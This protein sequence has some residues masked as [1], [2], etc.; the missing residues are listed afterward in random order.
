MGSFT[1]SDGILITDLSPDPV[2]SLDHLSTAFKGDT[3]SGIV[4]IVDPAPA[5]ALRDLLLRAASI[6]LLDVIVKGQADTQDIETTVNALMDRVTLSRLGD[7]VLFLLGLP[8]AARILVE[9][10]CGVQPPTTV[11]G[12]LGRLGWGRRR[13]ESAVRAY[14]YVWPLDFVRAVRVAAACVLLRRGHTVKDVAGRLAYGSTDTLAEHSRT[15][16]GIPPS[17]VRDLDE[18][19]LRRSL[20]VR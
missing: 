8:D 13:L 16:L 6:P 20:A 1:P 11:R 10:F 19:R 5:A 18:G 4:L 9:P 14:G 2:T 15:I 3:D 7:E 12:L 17:L